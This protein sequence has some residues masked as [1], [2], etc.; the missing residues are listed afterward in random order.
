M[1]SLTSACIPLSLCVCLKL[2]QLRSLR[3]IPASI[4]TCSESILQKHTVIL[5]SRNNWACWCICK[6]HL[7]TSVMTHMRLS[8]CLI[9]RCSSSGGFIRPCSSSRQRSIALIVNAQISLEKKKK[10]GI[11]RTLTKAKP[12]KS[13]PLQKPNTAEHFH[14]ANGW[15]LNV[16]LK[17][18]HDL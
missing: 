3:Y 2:Q 13:I 5:T 9:S 1:H 8:D 16:G 12:V 14:V 7:P 18:I 11:E 10:K 6:R 15:M 4:D 17:S